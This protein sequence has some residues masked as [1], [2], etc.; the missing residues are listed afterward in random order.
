MSSTTCR[1]CGLAPGPVCDS[2]VC[3]DEA[4]RAEVDAIF[5]MED[6]C[7]ASGHSEIVV[8]YTGE[9]GEQ[10]MCTGCGADWWEDSPGFDER[11]ER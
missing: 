11:W 8:T 5:T 2:Y 6:V 4:N 1:Y 3:N 9:A 10:L 7:E